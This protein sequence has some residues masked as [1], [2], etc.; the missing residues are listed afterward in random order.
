MQKI[1]QFSSLMITVFFSSSVCL[2]NFF[3][4]IIDYYKTYMGGQLD[5][6]L[7]SVAARCRVCYYVR[8]LMVFV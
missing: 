3:I 4:L 1:N 6:L 7:A 5:E 2:S 8:I